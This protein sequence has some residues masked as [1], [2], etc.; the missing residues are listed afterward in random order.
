MSNF[1]PKWLVLTLCGLWAA[2][3]ITAELVDVDPTRL[4]VRSPEVEAAM[5]NCISPD[6]H[7]RYE[8]KERA[9]LANQRGMFVKSVGFLVELLGPPMVLWFLTTRL[10]KA[11][12]R[13]TGGRRP[14][15]PGRGPPSIARWRVR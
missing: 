9:I 15:D 1:L 3:V 12:T 14:R 4:G 11:E 13:R 2:L 7:S 6:M 5:E 8:C 10:N